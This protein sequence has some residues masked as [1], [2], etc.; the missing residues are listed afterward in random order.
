MLS[1]SPV[2]RVGSISLPSSR[3]RSYPLQDSIEHALVPSRSESSLELVF[4]NN[5]QIDRIKRQR[6]AEHLESP[7]LYEEFECSSKSTSFRK[8][9][10]YKI[11]AAFDWSEQI[12]ASTEPIHL[13]T[14][15]SLLHVYLNGD[16][17]GDRYS[18][19][20]RCA[21][22]TTLSSRSSHHS[23]VALVS[24]LFRTDLFS[25][26]NFSADLNQKGMSIYLLCM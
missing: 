16:T 12:R 17:K 3:P 21:R 13:T 20:S 26:P 6:L 5:I 18:P 15:S 4:S 1:N 25:D 2:R 22:L 23:F 8:H 14:L 19:I 9:S 24:P 10:F 11:V 7:T